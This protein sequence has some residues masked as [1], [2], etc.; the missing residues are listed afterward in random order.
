MLAGM[1][2]SITAAENGANEEKNKQDAKA[3]GGAT[4]KGLETDLTAAEGVGGIMG[5]IVGVLGGWAIGDVIGGEFSMNIAIL[6]GCV[7]GGGIGLISGTSNGND[8]SPQANNQKQEQ[9]EGGPAG[10]GFFYKNVCVT[11]GPEDGP[12]NPFLI[13]E[14]INRSG[15]LF[16]IVNFSVSVY[17]DGG[18]LLEARTASISNFPA[19]SVKSFVVEFSN[20]KKHEIKKYKVDFAGR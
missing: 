18:I 15:Q 1:N 8:Q 7:I 3:S 4:S 9:A 12:D 2:D 10:N 14:L 5:A 13:G 19:N 16:E 11:P 20:I 17:D 6:I